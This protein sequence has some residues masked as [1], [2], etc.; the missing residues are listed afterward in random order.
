MTTK[1][2][3]LPIITAKTTMEELKLKTA[4][5]LKQDPVDLKDLPFA[6][7]FWTADNAPIFSRRKRSLS[8]SGKL[9]NL[10]VDDLF[11]VNFWGGKF[12]S[13]CYLM[14]VLRKHEREGF[15]D[16]VWMTK[17]RNLIRNIVG[18]AMFSEVSMQTP[19]FQIPLHLKKK[20]RKAIDLTL[21]ET[22]KKLSKKTEEVV[23]KA[24]PTLQKLLAI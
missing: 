4:A 20:K 24:E 22:P 19:V 10:K 12:E 8:L 14:K 5:T 17:K 7:G 2:T 11:Y 3:K 1:N 15:F 16:C 13:R 21:Q 6:D 23:V 18:Q 9:A